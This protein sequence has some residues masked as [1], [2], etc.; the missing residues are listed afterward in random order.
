MLLALA[1]DL[2]LALG[3]GLDILDSRERHFAYRKT[4]V[5]ISVEKPLDKEFSADEP[6]LCFRHT[7]CI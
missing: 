4:H 2:Y 7:A 1:W 3:V 6:E 5:T